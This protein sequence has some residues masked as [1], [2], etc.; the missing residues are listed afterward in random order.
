MIKKKHTE[1]NKQIVDRQNTKLLKNAYLYVHIY[2][3]MRQADLTLL[4]QVVCTGHSL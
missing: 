4:D 3:Y 1:M 2:I